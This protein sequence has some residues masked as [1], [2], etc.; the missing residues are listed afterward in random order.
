MSHSLTMNGSQAVAP[1]GC[2]RDD[3]DD[4]DVSTAM[5]IARLKASIVRMSP[6]ANPTVVRVQHYLPVVR[7][8]ELRG[9]FP[10]GCFVFPGDNGSTFELWAWRLLRL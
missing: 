3:Y 7:F 9:L 8:V 10:G 2:S 5:A 4:E 6:S 1:D